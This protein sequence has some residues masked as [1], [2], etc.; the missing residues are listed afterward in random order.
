MKASDVRTLRSRR[1]LLDAGLELLLQK[2]SATLSELAV[3]AG[4]GRATLYR[5]FDTREAL[6]KALVIECLAETEAVVKP[7]YEKALSARQTLESILTVVVPL[8]DK[9]HFLLS[10]WM[11]ASEDKTINDIYNQQLQALY[12]LIESAK[13]DGAIKSHL[14]TGLLVGVIDSLLYSTWWMIG[15]QMMTQ[16]QAVEQILETLFDGI[17]AC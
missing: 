15:S 17:E 1:A 16:E 4:V 8:A 14:S 6:V 3:H 11:V 9:F 2:P 13:A 10:L 12:E 7:I 5:H